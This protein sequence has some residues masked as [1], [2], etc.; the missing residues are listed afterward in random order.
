MPKKIAVGGQMDKQLLAKL[1]TQYGDENVTVD[2]K[3]DVEAAVGVKSGA[4]DY[5]IGACAT[6]A[7]AAIAMA[8]G[9]LGAQSCVSLSVPGKIVSDDEIAQAVSDGKKAFGFVN[10]DAEKIIPVLIQ[11]MLKGGMEG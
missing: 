4:F 11:S 5:Y 1:I 8:I 9:L 3:S 7:G 10:T 2:I 6:G